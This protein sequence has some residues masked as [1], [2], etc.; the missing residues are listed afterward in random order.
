M[1]L[2]GAPLNS[3]KEEK[4]KTKVQFDPNNKS[5]TP[6]ELRALV[7]EWVNLRS[8][9]QRMNKRKK[10]IEPMIKN[11]M[12]LKD[13]EEGDTPQGILK[14][15]ESKSKESVNEDRLETSL[16]DFLKDNNRANEA[17]KYVM[18]HRKVVLNKNLKFVER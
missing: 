6:T 1:S 15:A 14:F 4:T 8:E 5:S 18:T 16:K 7:L 11:I 10:E 9:T 13:I 17:V 2:Q 3:I 12:E